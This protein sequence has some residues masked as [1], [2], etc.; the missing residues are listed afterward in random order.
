MPLNWDDARFGTYFYDKYIQV[1]RNFRIDYAKGGVP[2][3]DVTIK[4]RN[5]PE[6]Q[7]AYRTRVQ[8]QIQQA[9][10]D[11]FLKK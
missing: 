8:N 11:T 1:F 10:V 7:E 2:K 5:Q 3:A 9:W 6:L 4:N